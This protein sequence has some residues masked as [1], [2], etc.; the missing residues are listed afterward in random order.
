MPWRLPHRITPPPTG[1]TVELLGRAVRDA[2]AHVE[3]PYSERIVGA[4][5]GPKAFPQGKCA[6]PLT[7]AQ[8][9]RLGPGDRGTR[10]LT[11]PK[12][13]APPTHRDVRAPPKA[14]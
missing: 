4:G 13:S 5:Q 11:Q 1:Y 7:R 2:V 8:P 3:V 12:P 6:A 9:S 14:V 10:S